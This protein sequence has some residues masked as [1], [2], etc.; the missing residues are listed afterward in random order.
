MES[1]RAR[2][3]ILVVE[4]DVQFRRYLAEVLDNEGYL[5]RLADSGVTALEALGE[6]TVDVVLTDLVMPGQDGVSLIRALRRSYPALHIVA[7][8]GRGRTDLSMDSLN[9]VRLLGA[10]CTLEKPFSMAELRHALAVV[11]TR[12]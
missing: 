7:M 11:F 9:L 3:S 5:V 4:D 10:D 2:P 1:V 8:S 12:H 6:S